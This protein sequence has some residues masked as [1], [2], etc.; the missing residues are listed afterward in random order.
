MYDHAGMNKKYEDLCP[1]A[2]VL[3]P[4]V[5]HPVAGDVRFYD[6]TR[7]VAD[8]GKRFAMAVALR[9]AMERAVSDPIAGGDEYLKVCQY[10]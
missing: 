7:H 4:I 10:V 3:P 5:M 9:Y 1:G 6:R 2:Q 8:I